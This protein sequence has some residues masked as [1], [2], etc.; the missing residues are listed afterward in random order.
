MTSIPSANTL[1]INILPTAKLHFTNG[2]NSG[3]LSSL[4]CLDKRKKQDLRQVSV[5]VVVM[6]RT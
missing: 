1:S 3:Y 6:Q 5:F 2:L 4:C